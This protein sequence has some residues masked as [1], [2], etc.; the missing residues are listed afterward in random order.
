MRLIDG[1]CP[2]ACDELRCEILGEISPN[3][4]V[5]VDL[6]SAE[7]AATGVAST[8][9]GLGNGVVEVTGRATCSEKRPFKIRQ[10]QCAHYVRENTAAATGEITLGHHQGNIGRYAI[11]SPH[12]ENVRDQF[13]FTIKLIPLRDT[14]EGI[15][16]ERH[17]SE[18]GNS[19]ATFQVINET[20]QPRDAAVRRRPNLDVFVDAF[21]RWAAEL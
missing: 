8:P 13:G 10:P 19:S 21:K 6:K 1:L 20:A 7:A 17:E 9:H 16:F 5:F 11:V 18:V 4:E 2:L 12:L 14:V 15:V 3:P